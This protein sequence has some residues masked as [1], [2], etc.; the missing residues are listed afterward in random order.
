MFLEKTQDILCL[1]IRIDHLNAIS[2]W[3]LA[4]R[5]TIPDQQK[6]SDVEHWQAPSHDQEN[7]GVHLSRFRWW[8][9]AAFRVSLTCRHCWFI[10]LPSNLAVN[11]P[12]LTK[13]V[14]HVRILFDVR[15]YQDIERVSLPRKSSCAEFQAVCL[16]RWY[17]STPA[18][19]FSRSKVLACI[20]TLSLN[21]FA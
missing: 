3:T 6:Y 15:I 1:R 10:E 18:H 11:S 19:P 8:K 21:P 14:S 16:V 9:I 20:L 12:N 13:P 5:S 7:E 2:F 17:R 4:A